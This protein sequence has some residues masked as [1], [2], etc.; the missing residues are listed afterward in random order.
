MSPRAREKTVYVLGAGFSHP[1]RVPL[2]AELVRE[3]FALRENYGGAHRGEVTGALDAFADFLENG[4]AIDP[5]RFA[6][7]QLEDVFTPIDHCVSNNIS[8]RSY[9]TRRLSELR[10]QIFSL[11]LFTLH[12]RMRNASHTGYLDRFARHLVA[13]MEPRRNDPDHEPVSV[14]STNWDS[15]LDHAIRRA[16]QASSTYGVLDYCCHIDPLGRD[17]DTVM[18]GLYA[19]GR[20]GFNV[21]LL[22]LH[23]STHWLQCPRCERLYAAFERD[24]PEAGIL[25][26]HT[27][28]VCDGAGGPGR[29]AGGISGDC[30]SALKSTLIM[31]TF[32]KDLT[33]F[34]IKLLWQNAAIELSEASR[35][36][37]IGYSL[38]LADYELRQLFVRTIPFDAE[39]EV[40]QP[41]EA[42]GAIRDENAAAF[43]RYQAFFGRRKLR[44]QPIGV[45]RWLDSLPSAAGPSK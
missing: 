24:A 28:R 21:K 1:A 3:I 31:P 26:Q 6:Q 23:G 2:Q 15:L 37:F 13:Q 7:V 29:A 9:D 22:K 32:L 43:R 33:N 16:L 34:Q 10:E 38:P 36:V 5:E 11:I 42:S 44:L 27:C 39:I 12:E 17:D 8:F 20:G 45:E 25:R 40:V 19:L 41:E 14:I 35:V 30:S 4:L 18:P